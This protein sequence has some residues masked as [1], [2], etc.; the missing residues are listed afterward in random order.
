MGAVDDL[1]KRSKE[2][3]LTFKKPSPL[4]EEYQANQF[5]EWEHK[6]FSV[7]YPVGF[8]WSDH[9]ISYYSDEDPIVV[10][11]VDRHPSYSWF[12]NL[13]YTQIIHGHPRG[14]VCYAADQ[15]HVVGYKPTGNEH[16]NFLE[17]WKRFGYS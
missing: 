13:D 11:E 15:C 10:A 4:S 1:L 6:T 12:S 16:K 8:K 5:L 7:L 2:L 9:I 14:K 17:R 3:R